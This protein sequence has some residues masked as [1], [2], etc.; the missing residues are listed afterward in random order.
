MYLL[1]FTSSI[2]FLYYRFLRSVLSAAEE[3]D[4]IIRDQTLSVEERERR[5]GEVTVEGATFD[6]LSLTMT[7]VAASADPTV[8]IQPLC[9]NGEHI[10]VSVFC[11]SLFY[12]IR[13]LLN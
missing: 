10:E 12:A 9:D 11:I 3:Y 4:K 8:Q 6:E 13:Y 2:Y 5:A 7:H 1:G